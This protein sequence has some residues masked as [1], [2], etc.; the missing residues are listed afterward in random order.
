MT[1]AYDV[2]VPRGT[3]VITRTDSG[4]TSVRDVS[5][6]V[7]VTTQS[8]CAWTAVSNASWI[9]ITSGSSGIDDGT[10]RYTAE[11]NTTGNNRTGTLT[12]A[13]QTFTLTEKK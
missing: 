9:T 6:P 4:A 1:I 11:A 13:G 10:V 3:R 5:G 12:I 8:G 2:I 7:S